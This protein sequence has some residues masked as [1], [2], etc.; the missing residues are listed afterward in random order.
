LEDSLHREILEEHARNP[1]HQEDLAGVTLA[2]SFTSLKTGNRCTVRIVSLDARIESV[3][4]KAEGS[5]L[6]IAC[7]SLM[8]SEI[9]GKSLKDASRLGLGVSLYLEGKGNLSL[10]GDLVAYESI[11]RFPERHD[12][13]LLGW[14]AL[15]LTLEQA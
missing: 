4:A 7:A 8:G 15:L 2:G 10:S 1:G 11:V 13:A 6:A 12:C 3:Q 9:E 5:A 14:R